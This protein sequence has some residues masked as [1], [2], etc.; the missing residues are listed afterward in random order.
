MPDDKLAANPEWRERHNAKM[1]LYSRQKEKSEA[2]GK[3]EAPKTLSAY[4]RP[5]AGIARELRRHKAPLEAETAK[6]DDADR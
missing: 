5:C 4:R 1:R 3:G 6:L 2:Q